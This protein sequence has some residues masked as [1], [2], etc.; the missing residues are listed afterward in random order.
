VTPV[1]WVPSASSYSIP[2][3]YENL[4]DQFIA[5]GAA[6]SGLPTNVFSDLEQ[7]TN[8]S[9]TSISYLLHAGSPIIDTDAFPTS[10]CTPDKGVIWSDG[11]S[12]SECVTNSQLFAEAGAITTQQ[13]LP[14][15]LAHVYMFFLPEGVETCFT[16][17]N[18]AHHGQCSLNGAGNQSFCGYHSSNGSLMI[19][20]MN[21]AFVDSPSGST[22]SSDAGSNTAG[23]ESPN[24]DIDADTEI[25][26]ASHEIS[27]TITDPTSLAWY[28]GAA[29]EVG[30][31]CAYIY[32]DSDSFQGSPG[33]QYNQT[34]NGHH[35]FIQE[36]FSNAAYA[37]NHAD[38][39]SL[40]IAP[41]LVVTA[42]SPT[43][44]EGGTV[45]TIT[46]A[47][48]G[49]VNSDGPSSL[50]TQPT[51]STTATSSS[52]VGTYP[53]MCSGA[54]D[55]NYTISYV[56]G[57]VTVQPPT[58][59]ITASSMTMD[60]GGVVPTIIPGYQG[61]VGQDGPSSLTTQPTCSTTA[62][63]SSPVGSYPSTCSG[64]SDPSY[65]IDY[66]SGTVT[67]QPVP[68]TIETT[69]LPN[70]TAGTAYSVQLTAIGGTPP[71]KWTH[72][73][74]LPTGVKLKSDGLLA[75]TPSSRK[76]ARSY[77]VSVKVTTKKS[78]GHPAQSASRTLTLTVS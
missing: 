28:D 51:C 42:S 60:Q 16:A 27:E 23:N 49:F 47:Y 73:G 1:Y 37:A 71:Y 62:T 6:D 20:D 72:T 36:E 54:A 68:L 5:D 41:P 32:G 43:M 9:A 15:D 31:D 25:S 22:C 65:T 4:I 70:A 76:P 17:S 40:G 24:G 10:G 3:N 67:V 78:R 18:S 2:A 57:T 26:I 63:S 39:C 52:S 53:S 45:P 59:T 14:V 29:N 75:G 8:G 34:I 21:Y 64:A 33:A 77:T 44:S 69:M 13:S 55:S 38:A 48:G 56:A 50:T 19:T 11:T 7:Y 12:Y 66:V 61:F 30:D 35:Y 58:L 74:A 46:P